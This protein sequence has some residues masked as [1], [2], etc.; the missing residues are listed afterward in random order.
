MS[1]SIFIFKVALKDSKSI[2]RKIALKGSQ[3][4]D[5]LHECIFDAFDRYDDHL[6]SF[7]FP[8][9]GMK[10][11]RRIMQESLEYTCPYACE[12]TGPF[13]SDAENAAKAKIT[14]L[15]LKPKQIFYYLF[16]FGDEWWHEITVEE[17]DAEADRGKY[18]RV[19]DQKGKSPAQ[20]PNDD[21]E[22]EYEDEEEED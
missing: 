4:L 18:P 6:Y 11:A 19:L 15:K 20:Y 1:A 14:L 12:D 17:I 2:W 8:P 13:G 9:P 22:G 16:D 3:T 7:F 5:D 10:I 21:E